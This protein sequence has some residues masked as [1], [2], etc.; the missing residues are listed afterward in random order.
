MQNF[1]E[2]QSNKLLTIEALNDLRNQPLFLYGA[3]RV[4]KTVLK[5]ASKENLVID[6]IYVS[7][8]VSN[9]SKIMGIPVVE[10]S[11]QERKPGVLLVCMLEKL[12]EEIEEII[13]GY[14]FEK[15]YYISDS[16]FQK[17]KYIN[18]DYEVDTMYEIEACKR[19]VQGVSAQVGRIA[20]QVKNLV[21]KV[22]GFIVDNKKI[23][24]ELVYA[25]N[26]GRAISTCAWITDADIKAGD[27]A[28]NNQYLYTMFRAID[29]KKF[30]SILDIGMGSTTKLIS[31]YVSYAQN[32]KHY[33]I[34]SDLDWIQFMKDYWRFSKET[35]IIQMNYKMVEYDDEQVRC[36][37][38]FKEKLKE[39][40]FDFISIDAPYGGDMKKYSRRDLWEILPGCLSDSWIIMIDDVDRIGEQNTISLIKECL[41][42]YEIPYTYNTH[43][44]TKAF[45]IFTS[46]DNK[47][48]GTV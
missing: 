34:E 18:G 25:Q 14:S 31:Q 4:A 8:I 26:F 16:L 5:Y 38:G 23:I 39:K 45:G 46:L 33:V 40:K 27:M 24:N 21:Q 48:F 11:N 6:K 17:I 15:I 43:K 1:E 10:I 35:E 36:Y 22:D 3:G 2:K 47:F 30:K 37:D 19:E 28:V 9:P 44:T 42:N 13:S 12:H 20:T 29:S 7:D 32:A 41:E